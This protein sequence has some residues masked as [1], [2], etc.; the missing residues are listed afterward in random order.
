MNCKICGNEVKPGS[1]FCENCGAKIEEETPVTVETQ[2]ESKVEEPVE[3]INVE[4]VDAQIVS[5]PPKME[6]TENSTSYSTGYS[7][8]TDNATYSQNTSQTTSNNSSADR[9][10][11]TV[12][13]GPAPQSTQSNGFAI[14]SLVC[15]ILSL[16]CCCCTPLSVVLGGVG[17]GLGIYVV[18]SK[19]P[20][21][22]MAI[23]GIACGGVGLFFFLISM[24]VSASGAFK[25]I[26]D[27]LDLLDLEDI[28]ESL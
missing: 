10:Y 17:V 15:G 27:S 28:I 16:V 26:T 12:N 2:E 1:K 21:K 8:T 5:E 4:R 25:N 20:G 19:L 6:S 3:K 22:E 24:L 9:A 14:A 11:G 7:Q 18:Y 13:P 23:A